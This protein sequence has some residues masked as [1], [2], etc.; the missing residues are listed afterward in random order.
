M[1]LDAAKI[2]ALRVEWLDDFVDLRPEW[3]QAVAAAASA[4]ATSLSL[5]GLAASGT[6][7]AGTSF[8]L[9]HNGAL[10][11]YALTA[12]AVIATGAATAKIAPALPAAIAAGTAIR[13]EPRRKSLYNKRTGRLFFS[14]EELEDYADRAMSMKGRAIRAADD[15]ERA[16]F[17]AV[18]FYAFETMLASSEFLSAILADDE[19]GNAAKVLEQMKAL[20]AEDESIVFDAEMGPQT[21]RLTR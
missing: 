10:T 19:R 14:D 1:I 8:E 21:L 7:R 6:L 3:G 15:P 16:L 9:A 5:S 18:R 2:R 12:D 11:R 13:P 4:G 20:H 17:R